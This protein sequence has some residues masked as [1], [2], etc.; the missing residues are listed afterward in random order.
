[1]YKHEEPRFGKDDS[2][3][4]TVGFIWQTQ[5]TDR[6]STYWALARQRDQQA[7]DIDTRARWPQ[8]SC[9]MIWQFIPK[10]G[11]WGNSNWTRLGTKV[12]PCDGTT[13]EFSVGP[14]AA[15]EKDL[16]GGNE[17]GNLMTIILR[18]QL[19]RKLSVMARAEIFEAGAFQPDE[20]SVSW[21]M[22]W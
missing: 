3:V 16:G 22:R 18:Q 5:P 15:P 1:M 21:T 17:R 8:Y 4:H 13:F 6:V 12:Y 19:S 11:E 14:V 20:N 9:L 7:G 10:L 2:Y